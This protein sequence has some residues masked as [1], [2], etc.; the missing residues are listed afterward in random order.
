ME[1][2][3][4]N[5]TSAAT[6]THSVLDLVANFERKVLEG[7]VQITVR[8]SDGA[9]ALVLDTNHLDIRA[10][11]RCAGPAWTCDVEE[12]ASAAAADAD[13]EGWA[14]A[15]ANE[16]FGR[17]LSIP[18]AAAGGATQR[19][20]VDYATTAEGG[21]IQWLDAVATSDK[22]HPFLFTQCQAIHARS[23]FPCQDTPQVKATYAAVVTAPTPLRPVLS[24][25][26]NGADA[27]ATVPAAF[28]HA[29]RAAA[30]ATVAT[31]SYW[32]DQPVP[33]ASYLVAIA[34]GRLEHHAYDARCGVWAE[35]SVLDAA[36]AEFDETPDFLRVGEAICGAYEWGRYDVLCMPSSFPYGGMEN[37][38]LTFVTPSLLAG[39]K[40]LADVVIHEITHSWTGNLVT[41]KVRRVLPAAVCGRM[42]S[43]PHRVAPAQTS[44]IAHRAATHWTPP[45]PP[46]LPPSLPPPQTWEHFWLNEGWTTHVQRKIVRE[47]RG[48]AAAELDGLN[49]QI[50][51][52]NSVDRY[53]ATHDF[54]RM[55]PPLAG[56]D[57]DDAFSSIPYEKGCTFLTYLEFLVGGHE[58]WMPFVKVSSFI[59][60]YISRESCSQFDSLNLTS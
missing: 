52:A 34:I 43:L 21:A 50:A 7:S 20:V 14:L 11:R 49:G 57:P 8:V 24:A 39:D 36:R 26:N 29:T 55:V 58:A 18:L 4:S 5:S 25:R 37:P 48:L 13:V 3:H 47:V 9:T 2:A 41:N 22:E 38:C 35:P 16:P 28:A 45:S 42:D 40:S 60:R 31:A 23:L 51:L 30:D 54:T 27:L 46:S 53:G 12:G 33:C 56:I 19:F 17:A 15:E 10:V 44:S 32:F 6:V 59:Y 1:R